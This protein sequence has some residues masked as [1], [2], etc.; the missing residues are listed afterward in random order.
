MDIIE[1]R[2]KLHEYVDLADEEHLMAIF[3]LIES[4]LKAIHQRR[5]NNSTSQVENVPG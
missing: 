3:L 5:E 1:L 2:R 4:D